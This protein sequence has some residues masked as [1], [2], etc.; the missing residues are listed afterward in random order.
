MPQAQDLKRSAA[1]SAAPQRARLAKSASRGVSAW[2]GPGTT[3]PRSSSSTS[4]QAAIASTARLGRNTPLPLAAPTPAT[5]AACPVLAVK[6]RLLVSTPDPK[7]AHTC[8]MLAAASGS[9][10]K[11]ASR[12]RHSEPNW[13]E[14][15]FV[16][17]SGGMCS[18]SSR[19]RSITVRR[20]ES[21]GIT[22]ARHTRCIA[23]TQYPGERSISDTSWRAITLASTHACSHLRTCTPACIRTSPRSHLQGSGIL[24]RSYTR[25]RAGARARERTRAHG[26]VWKGGGEEERHAQLGS[27]RPWPGAPGTHMI[28]L[29]AE[30]LAKLERRTTHTAQH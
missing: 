2:R 15:C 12:P 28:V 8:P 20:G 30:K 23:G 11:S 14:S 7:A 16:S 1:S 29:D 6:D 19:T 10:S 4:S 3:S 24:S 9:S 13:L 27:C 25:T 22:C 21:L 26:R 18:A 5:A 17:C